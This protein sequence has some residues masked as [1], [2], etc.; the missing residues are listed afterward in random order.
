MSIELSVIIPAHNAAS[1]IRFQLEALGTQTVQDGW[2]L[3][4]VDHRSSDHTGDIA[5]SY[6]DAM[7][8]MRVLR[9]DTGSNVAAARNFG[10][11]HAR[12]VSLAFCD[13]DDVVDQNWVK[14][15]QL[16]LTEHPLV[17]GHLEHDV[18]NHQSSGYR[19]RQQSQ[20][21]VY[22]F[23]SPVVI[24]ANFGC[25][26]KVWDQVGGNDES[27]N[28][29]D[30]VEFAL[31]VGRELG[32]SPSFE[33][34]AIV[35]YRH[36]S[37]F[38]AAWLQGARYGKEHPRILAQYSDF[39]PKRPRSFKLLV[40]RTVLAISALPHIYS[41]RGRLLFTFQVARLIGYL[42]GMVAHM[43]MSPPTKTSRTNSDGGRIS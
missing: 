2:E 13:A 38:K 16:A 5:R 8:H 23:G 19:K 12:G 42:G 11:D 35:H 10:A 41:K 33:S 39:L 22:F 26:K 3:I 40:G 31:R 36:R 1:T 9:S 34:S 29:S 7:P 28:T 20:S 6:L 21:L 17:A 14:A 18:L 25:W 24:G 32:I 30:D 15:M 43:W 27:L 4:V 37:D